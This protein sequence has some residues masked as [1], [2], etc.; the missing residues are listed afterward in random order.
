MRNNDRGIG[1]GGV[2]TQIGWMQCHDVKD[3]YDHNP[4]VPLSDLKTALI[5]RFDSRKEAVDGILEI[6]I[7]CGVVECPTPDTMTLSG[8]ISPRRP[9]QRDLFT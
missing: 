4:P 3:P 7:R 2:T 6:A 5:E 1:I 9:R 8:T